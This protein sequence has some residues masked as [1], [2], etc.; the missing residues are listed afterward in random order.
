MKKE[1]KKEIKEYL[2]DYDVSRNEDWF[3]WIQDANELLKKSL[4]EIERL[5]KMVKVFQKH[6]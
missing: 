3:E 6:K 5:E 4:I 2:R 1:I